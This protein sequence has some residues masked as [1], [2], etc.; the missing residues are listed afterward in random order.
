MG[1]GPLP[2]QQPPHSLQAF[3][4]QIPLLL[5]ELLPPILPRKDRDECLGWDSLRIK[6]GTVAV[7]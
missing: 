4:L 6:G 5:P 7:S 3:L 2:G 1:W